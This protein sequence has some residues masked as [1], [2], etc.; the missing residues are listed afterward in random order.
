M[1]NN[2]IKLKLRKLYV[3]KTIRDRTGLICFIRPQKLSSK[4]ANKTKG[5]H[6]EPVSSATKGFTPRVFQSQK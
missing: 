3:L 2:L 5:N 4:I 1:R 6:Y